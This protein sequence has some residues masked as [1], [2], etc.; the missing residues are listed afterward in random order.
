MKERIKILVA[1]DSKIIR[2]FVTRSLID[3]GYDVDS[4]EDGL[5]ALQ[6]IKTNSYDILLTDLIMPKMDGISLV[7]EI[8]KLEKKDDI[9]VIVMTAHGTLE[10]AR[11]AL[12]EGAAG[13]VLKPFD[14]KEVE[15]IIKDVI[16]KKKKKEDD[17][18]INIYSELCAINE[19]ISSNFEIE[20]ILSMIFQSA[21]NNTS[22][23]YCYAELFDEQKERNFT[24]SSHP[25]KEIE[26]E[27]SFKRFIR[28]FRESSQNSKAVVLKRNSEKIY[29]LRS[30]CLIAD[31]S[32]YITSESNINAIVSV[33]L[34]FSGGYRGEMVFIS[35][36][37]N[38]SQMNEND[39]QFLTF[40]SMQASM[41]ID[42]SMLLN[43]LNNSYLCA[44]NSLVM[45]IEAR[46]KYTSGHSQRVTNI[47]ILLGKKLGL[48]SQEIK[49]ID[50]GGRLHDIG[51][52]G[53]SDMILNKPGK[54]TDNE[55]E[56]IK[57]H[58]IIGDKII[59]PIKSLQDVR[60][61]VKHHHEREDG[62]GYPDGL[63]GDQIPAVVK[64]IIAA[65][66]YDAMDSKR[67]YRDRLPMEYIK[68]EFIALR[69]KQFDPLISDLMVKLIESGEIK[70][71]T[72]I[73]NSPLI[74]LS[75][76]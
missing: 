39:I 48:S 44:I 14:F 18:K 34:N 12:K 62:K 24:L 69:G 64:V 4:A 70:K 26:K 6:K 9:E 38:D 49:I 15:G 61:I 8:A 5:E 74:R 45:G 68:N 19:K 30:R 42:N 72:A 3:R 23:D 22:A 27:F 67:I 28:D 17:I 54:L 73:D 55:R 11:L 46:D 32:N 7:K 37:S 65:D 31:I 29:P 52:I 21:L 56:I 20:H 76:A 1:D 71:Y 43:D 59:A 2:K 60:C 16:E 25:D 47:G 75:A 57:N 36:S 53:I 33:P 13:Y 66:S 35:H 58:T 40:L 63:K 41:S 10:T 51:K 50:N